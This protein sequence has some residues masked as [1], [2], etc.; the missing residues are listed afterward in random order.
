MRQVVRLT[1]TYSSDEFGVCSAL[2]ELGGLV[3]M[4]DA[5]G[6]NSTYTT[7]DEPRWY[8]MDSMIYIS[9]I[10]EMEAI[11]GDDSKLIQDIVETSSRL[12]PKF[13]A[14]VGA[15]IPY[16][17]GTDYDAISAII[18]EET[19]IPCFG[20]PTNGMQYYTQGVSLA[21]AK[22]TDYYC[23]GASQSSGGFDESESSVAQQVES[24]VIKVNILGATPLDFSINST[25]DSIKKWISDS[26]MKL[27]ACLAMGSTLEDIKT[28][29]AADVNLVI[30]YGGLESARI[31]KDKF[32]METMANDGLCDCNSAIIILTCKR[33]ENIH[34]KENG[35]N[36]ED[37]DACVHKHVRCAHLLLAESEDVG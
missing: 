10:S 27:Q 28:A 21:L 26:G 6:C 24:N 34:D 29:G 22:I 37:N 4:H 14:I 35:E 25:L 31:L 3:V 8:D 13:I 32:N 15:P 1:S 20:F 9:A 19:G 18:T 17:T 12:K 11:L 7:H 5:S 2:Y 23:E 16:M 36:N 33:D 30:S